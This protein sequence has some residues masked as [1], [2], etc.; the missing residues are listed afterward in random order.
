MMNIVRTLYRAISSY[1]PP[2]AQI[3]IFR[4]RLSAK[5]ELR[6]RRRRRSLGPRKRSTYEGQNVAVVGLFSTRSGL[7]RGAELLARLLEV[8]GAAVTRV[9][10]ETSGAEKLQHNAI[11]P[12]ACE[13]LSRQVSDVVIVVNP[14][15]FFSVLSKFSAQWLRERRV[16]AHWVW[17][18]DAVDRYWMTAI[19]ICDEVWTASEFVAD[20]LKPYCHPAGVP[21]TVLPYP[22]DL[23][24]FNPPSFEEKVRS[25]RKLRIPVDAFV[26]GYS[27]AASSNFERKNPL[28]AIAAFQKAFTRGEKTLLLIRILDGYVYPEGFAAL[29]KC[30][31]ADPRIIIIE[32]SFDLSIAEFYAAIDLYVSPARSEGYGLN[33]VEAAQAGL[34]VVAVAWSLSSD[35]LKRPGIIQAAYSL[36]AVREDQGNYATVKKAKWADP[37]IADMANKIL[38]VHDQMRPR[39]K[40]GSRSSRSDNVHVIH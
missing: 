14:P 29:N 19:N 1:L 6:A 9:N 18:L 10:F 8:K 25:R 37:D 23:D 27:F 28:G 35:V 38:S 39:G 22:V 31:S 4:L 5:F 17:E 36:T 26:V 12:M 3:L 32:R 30:A 2:D 40:W 13:R 11:T 21:L 16:I 33:I 7:G 15:I 20:V 24:P 34:P